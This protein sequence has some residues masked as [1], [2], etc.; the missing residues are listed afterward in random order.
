MSVETSNHATA[1]ARPAPKPQSG[2]QPVYRSLLFGPILFALLSII[3]AVIYWPGLNGPF[4]LDDR[5]SIGAIDIQELSIAELKRETASN[6]SGL[7]GRPISVLSLAV[8]AYTS[9]MNP[10]AFKYNNVMLHL[11]IGW[12]LLWLG[13]LII[14]KLIKVEAPRAWLIASAAAGLWL[15][16]PLQVSTALYAVQHMAQL[17][18]A[19]SLMAILAY[20]LGRRRIQEGR[21]GGLLLILATVPI[22]T[23]LS[24]FSKENGA[25]TPLFILIIEWLVLSR[26][27]APALPRA[28]NIALFVVSIL[29]LIL[30]T[31]Y[32]FTHLDTL[33]QEFTNRPFDMDERLLTQARVLW[34]YLGLIFI[35]KISAMG[36]FQ[37]DFVLS[38]GLDPVTLLA[39][40][41]LL[42][43][44]ALIFLLRR[45]W[46]AIA[47]GI[48]WFFVGHAMESTFLPLEL[49]FEHRN[50]LAMYG[51]ILAVAILLLGGTRPTLSLK[52][53]IL[54]TIVILSLFAIQTAIRLTSW[55]SITT[56]TVVALQDH[57]RSLRAN[58][59]YANILAK[60]KL[61]IAGAQAALWRSTEVAPENPAPRLHLISA[62]CLAKSMPE[63]LID[64]ATKL[65]ESN[66][67]TP[68]A[69]SSI[70]TLQRRLALET[71]PTMT[72]EQLLELQ[73]AALRN[74]KLP[75]RFRYLLYNL[76]ARTNLSLRRF[77]AAAAAYENAFEL[78]HTVPAGRQIDVLLEKMVMEM[79]F[80]SKEQ[81]DQTLARLIEMDKN[82]PIDFSTKIRTTLNATIREIRETQASQGTKNQAPPKAAT[83][84]A[85]E[86]P[87]KAD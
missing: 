84:V 13:G 80:L 10:R 51:L 74:K 20:L 57:P 87:P 59:E 78:R 1:N 54:G 19:F 72:A 52:A 62:Y 6:A 35:P 47:F 83:V 70:E 5:A 17:A 9:G 39:I 42:V 53:G 26:Q 75:V 3:T 34:F 4:L 64:S 30:G 32:V 58:S 46:P 21:R 49:V 2:A 27:G 11:L 71:C 77:E 44:L 65:L 41:G 45:S 76:Y 36:L 8:T 81:A 12:L 33:L 68:Y 60:Y 63:G 37:D 15:L 16:H 24:L 69:I 23:L 14:P 43:L 40:A 86:P 38:T 67:I 61:D 31:L 50:Y 29:P 73:R 82:S 25:L 28:R 66:F 85:V 7:L 55:Q 48:A 56:F 79:R 18:A 22:L